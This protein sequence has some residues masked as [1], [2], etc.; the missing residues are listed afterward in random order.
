MSTT[1]QIVQPY[2]SIK[3]DNPYEVLSGSQIFHTLQPYLF[4]NIYQHL[5]IPYLANIFILAHLC[6]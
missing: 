5:C 6:Q 1:I 2:V 4:F 3:N